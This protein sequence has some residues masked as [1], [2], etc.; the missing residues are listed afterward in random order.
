[1]HPIYLLD[2]SLSIEISYCAED[3]DLEDNICVKVTESCP[4]EVKV[5]K[6][7]E[8]HLYLTQQQAVALANALLNAV[9][10]SAAE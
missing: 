8:S 1:M 3:A 4:E 9:R 2:D 10:Q 6:H 7:D 5:F